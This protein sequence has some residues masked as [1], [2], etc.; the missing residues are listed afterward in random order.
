MNQRRMLTEE[1]NKL[2]KWAYSDHVTANAYYMQ[3]LPQNIE[4]KTTWSIFN[5]KNDPEL[6]E[7]TI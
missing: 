4:E 3:N 6:P 2:K 1:A 5:W 7:R